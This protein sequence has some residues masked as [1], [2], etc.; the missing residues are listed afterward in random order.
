MHESLGIPTM[1]SGTGPAGL[2]QPT[3]SLSRS[4]AETLGYERPKNSEEVVAF[5]T[6]IPKNVHISAYYFGQLL[7]TAEAKAPNMSESTQFQMA[8]TSYRDGPSAGLRAINA[9]LKGNTSASLNGASVNGTANM[10]VGK[11]EEHFNRKMNEPHK[12]GQG[13]LYNA[14]RTELTNAKHAFNFV[15]NTPYIEPQSATRYK[16]LPNPLFARYSGPMRGL[17]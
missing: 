7:D 4:L 15:M 2:G 13:N 17:W 6:S 11:I 5:Q 9:L 14:M 12:I 16:P 3:Q 8:Y 10:P 1:A